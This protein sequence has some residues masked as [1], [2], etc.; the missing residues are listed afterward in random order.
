MFTSN[1]SYNVVLKFISLSTVLILFLPQSLLTILLND[2]FLGGG[3]DIIRK[4]KKS[5]NHL[6]ER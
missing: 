2:F 5:L 3:V 1:S 6:N 4:L